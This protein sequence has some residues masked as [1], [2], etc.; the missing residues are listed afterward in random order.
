M[1]GDA[2]TATCSLEGEALSALEVP[3]AAGGAPPPPR[4]RRRLAAARSLTAGH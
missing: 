2:I 4:R 1:A 3:V